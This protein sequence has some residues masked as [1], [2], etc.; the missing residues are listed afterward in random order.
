MKLTGVT[1]LKNEQTASDFL[2]KVGSNMREIR[3]S[4][5]MT[6]SEVAKAINMA[7]V[8]YGIIERGQIGTSLKTLFNIATILNVSPA[9]LLLD[10]DEIFLTKK[11]IV[12]LYAQEEK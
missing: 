8:S 12:A 2:K 3:K 11:D 6:Q 7:K 9:Q 4:R 10:K 1:A 5:K